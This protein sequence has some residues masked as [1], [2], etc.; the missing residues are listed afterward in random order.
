MLLYAINRAIFKSFYMYFGLFYLYWQSSNICI[1]VRCMFERRHKQNLKFGI[2]SNQHH[3]LQ[4]FKRDAF[5]R[6][7]NKKNNELRAFNTIN[8]LSKHLFFSCVTRPS[9]FF[10]FDHFSLFFCHSMLSIYFN[11]RKMINHIA[12]ISDSPGEQ[13][14]RTK[15]SEKRNVQIGKMPYVAFIWQ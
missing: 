12:C 5:C 6:Y 10:Q 2:Y 7:L 15:P 8:L 13:I 3:I 14:E 4:D 11:G 9:Y 1:D